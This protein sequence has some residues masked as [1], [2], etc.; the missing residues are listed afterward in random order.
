MIG[1]LANFIGVTLGSSV[2]LLAKKAIPESWNSVIMRG[3]GLCTLYIG[4]SGALVGENT[5]ILI[6]SMGLLRLLLYRKFQRICPQGGGQVR[7][8]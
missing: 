7:R 2:G 8:Q 1:V 4:F 5:I 6:L 3:I